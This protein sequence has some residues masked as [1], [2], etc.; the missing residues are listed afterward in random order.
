MSVRSGWLIGLFKPSVS[1]LFFPYFFFLSIFL[2]LVVEVYFSLQF[3]QFYFT[4]IFFEGG[5]GV[6]AAYVSSHAKS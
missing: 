6:P 1:L 3:C 2:S 4:L 5:G